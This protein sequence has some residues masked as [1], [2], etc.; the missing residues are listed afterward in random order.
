MTDLSVRRAMILFVCRRRLSSCSMS[1]CDSS[2]LIGAIVVRS[3]DAMGENHNQSRFDHYLFGHVTVVTAQYQHSLLSCNNTNDRQYLCLFVICDIWTMRWTTLTWNP[4]THVAIVDASIILACLQWAKTARPSPFVAIFH[5][6]IKYMR[7]ATGFWQCTF[8]HHLQNEM[9]NII[10]EAIWYQ[11]RVK[12]WSCLM[13]YLQRIIRCWDHATPSGDAGPCQ[14]I[15]PSHHLV[16]FHLV[17]YRPHS[18]IRYTHRTHKIFEQLKFTF[19]FI[20]GEILIGNF[21]LQIVDFL[22]LRMYD[23]SQFAD[24]I[25]ILHGNGNKSKWSSKLWLIDWKA[26][27]FGYMIVK[28]TLNSSLGMIDP[29]PFSHGN[30]RFGL[31]SHSSR[32]LLSASSFSICVQPYIALSHEMLSLNQQI[33]SSII[34]IDTQNR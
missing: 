10:N 9:H 1:D 22:L 15:A 8:D 24:T 20:D 5:E 4:S 13:F 34:C 21:V 7:W 28:F 30:G 32:W 27:K 18:R 17:S 14:R 16:T 11:N 6:I 26:T 19:Q 12:R 3:F 33:Q 29:Q 25:V 31:C 2:W 23:R